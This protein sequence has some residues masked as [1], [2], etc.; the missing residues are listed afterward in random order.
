MRVR[1][2]GE[3]SPQMQTVCPYCQRPG[4]I[5]ES[6]DACWA[7]LNV[8]CPTDGHILEADVD[9][10]NSTVYDPCSECGTT[11]ERLKSNGNFLAVARKNPATR[12]ASR[13]PIKAW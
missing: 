5:H 3:G 6:D 11:W 4:V 13:G 8:D 2:R 9:D 12:V 7:S 10:D 1:L